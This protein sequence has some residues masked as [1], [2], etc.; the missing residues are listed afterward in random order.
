MC[1]S[2]RET[3]RG[4]SA[5]LVKRKRKRRWKGVPYSLHEEGPSSSS[6]FTGA[7]A[8]KYLT[9]EAEFQTED[10]LRIKIA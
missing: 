8:F 1:I 5:I 7:P 10:R 2:I 4:L 6:S 9:F 3:D